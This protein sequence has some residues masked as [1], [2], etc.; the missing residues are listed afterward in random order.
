MIGAK[1]WEILTRE[2]EIVDEELNWRR[3]DMKP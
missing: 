1:E 3:R 2:V